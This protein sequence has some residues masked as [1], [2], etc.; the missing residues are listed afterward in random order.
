MADASQME[1]PVQ[2]IGVDAVADRLVFDEKRLQFVLNAV[3][4]DAKVAVVSVVGAFRTG[5][6]FLLDLFLRYLRAGAPAAGSGATADGGLGWVGFDDGLTDLLRYH[7]ALLDADAAA[8]EDGA[9]RTR[10]E[11]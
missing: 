5:K 10:A 6:S 8:A 7:V 11:L 4:R 2:I 1:G 9:R 3:P